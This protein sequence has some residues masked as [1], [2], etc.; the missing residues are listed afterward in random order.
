MGDGML[1]EMREGRRFGGPLQPMYIMGTK[2]FTCFS[3]SRAGV[4][5]FCEKRFT[6]VNLSSKHQIGS[7][8]LS[9]IIHFSRRHCLQKR[10]IRDHATVD[11]LGE[12][13]N[14]FIIHEK[15]DR[16][17]T[18]D[19]KTYAAVIPIDLVDVVGLVEMLGLGR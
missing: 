4:L 5:W 19:Q 12:E 13:Q 8:D 14:W 10:S 15:G 6:S 18:D 17:G 11:Q 16:E 9:T 7:R 3:R 2:S 1:A